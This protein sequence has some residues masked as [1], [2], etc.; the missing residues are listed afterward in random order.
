MNNRTYYLALDTEYVRV[1]S[2]QN[3]LLSWQACISLDGAT[4]EK[5]YIRYIDKNEERPK[6]QDIV[7]QTFNEV[8]IP[9][10]KLDGAHIIII[11]HYCPAEISM[12]SENFGLKK[13]KDM[14]YL[15]QNMEYV[16]KT[17]ISLHAK[18]KNMSIKYRDKDNVLQKCNLSYEF[19]DTKLIAPAGVQS[20][21]ALSQTLDDPKL[22]KKSMSYYDISHMDWVMKYKKKKFT[23]Y[24]INDVKATMSIFLELQNN[25]RK[26]DT[27]NNYTIKKTIGS[28]AVSYY[29]NYIND[30]N[31][32]LLDTIL[33]KKRSIKLATDDR[34]SECYHGGRNETYFIGKAPGGY[35]FFD[36]DYKNAYPT[37]LSM[38]HGIDWEASPKFIKNIEQLL[39][40]DES[41]LN[42]TYVQAHFKFPPDTLYPCLPD[43]HETYGLIYPLE[44]TTYTTAH[45]IILA[46]KMGAKVDI[47]D[48]KEMLPLKR[49]A[50]VF[51]PFKG[52]Y[53]II[54]RERSK[55]KKKSMKN[56]LFK[57]YANTLYG[58]ICQNVS[59]KKL[60][61]LYDGVAK[62][63]GDSTITS[64]AFAANVTGIMRAA[65]GELLYTATQLNLIY[66]KDTYLPLNGVTDGA[67]IG[68]KISN[69]SNET[70]KKIE[71]NSFSNIYE[72]LPEFINKLEESTLIKLMKKTRY[73]ID[74]KNDDTYLEIK[75][76]SNKMWTFKT[77]GSVGYYDDKLTVLTKAGHKPPMIEDVHEELIQ[78]D[79]QKHK[80]KRPRSKEES[81]QWLLNIYYSLPEIKMYDLSR[82]ITFKDLVNTSN[83]YE[84]MITIINNQKTNLDFDY[85]RKPDFDNESLLED[86]SIT[87]LTNINTIPM[88]NKDE[89]LK[90][91]KTAENIRDSGRKDHVGGKY[92]GY[93]ATPIKVYQ[94]VFNDETPKFG[95]KGT[96]G[97]IVQYVV[98][99][100]I[101]NKLY[102]Y[103]ADYNTNQIEK[104]FL[105]P[106]F[107]TKNKV[108]SFINREMI[109]TLKNK[110]FIPANLPD[111]NYTRLWVK[112]TLK[113]LDILP[114]DKLL[115]ILIAKRR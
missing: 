19:F 85:K 25:F 51:H 107:S 45:E 52:F 24:A 68:V 111:N 96:K 71:S 22:H 89:M 26:L 83:D 101:K 63:L 115:A 67:M 38:L 10:G 112:K 44:G 76:I 47:I 30:I 98:Q 16:R 88:H 104:R 40:K 94:K 86:E 60:T 41:Q 110:V 95:Q 17:I 36:I 27:S 74:D 78:S 99:A 48:A 34:F 6:L 65:L 102:P 82:L 64:N 108:K 32:N 69:F 28:A 49:D 61:G 3:K 8:G 53:K 5:G 46:H 12:L 92:S 7:L 84:D 50:K 113:K 75:S 81:A 97:I 20:L 31:K 55:Y 4:L 21:D 14:R 15:T 73:D 37:C 70:I 87:E 72:I 77:R 9:P 39:L 35:I 93:R 29:S 91:R 106:V 54:I 109:R 58:K 56:L 66:G 59:K 43:F 23:E 13:V 2:T 57:E 114:N 80:F 105:D 62:E 33:G 100:Y 79:G 42:A 18:H 1:S 103:T 11:C 90:W